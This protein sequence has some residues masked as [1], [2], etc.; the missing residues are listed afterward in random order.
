ML[1]MPIEQEIEQEHKV[2]RDWNMRQVIAI[3]AGGSIAIAFYL[4]F[5]DWMLMVIFSL[6]FALVLGYFTKK[7]DNDRPAEEVFMKKAEQ[8]IYKNETRKYRTRNMYFPLMNSYYGKMRK[9][10]AGLKV[11]QK[12]LKKQEK[13]R[14]KKM[15]SSKIRGIK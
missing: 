15:K 6:P 10:D 1:N 2:F 7:D 12:E 9:K 13:I 14:K 3:L 8:K 4:Y 11:V 5:R